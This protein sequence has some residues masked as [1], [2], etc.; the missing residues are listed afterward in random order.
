M[1]IMSMVPKS[2]NVSPC[3]NWSLTSPMTILML[4]F[5]RM[6]LRREKRTSTKIH[7]V[8]IDPD[9][10]QEKGWDDLQHKPQTL[11]NPRRPFISLSL[12]D[13]RNIPK[14]TVFLN[15]FCFLLEKNPMALLLANLSSSFRTFRMWWSSR[16][17]RRM[18]RFFRAG[19]CLGGGRAL[20]MVTF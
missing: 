20:R 12:Y 4:G 11:R 19:V 10:N 14:N 5:F 16:C 2:C 8:E 18:T 15:V 6:C 7:P 17:R 3:W 13:I 1:V 9:G